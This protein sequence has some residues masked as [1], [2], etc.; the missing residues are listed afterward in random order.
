M[1]SS[2][3]FKWEKKMN[4]RV[5]TALQAMKAPLNHEKVTCSSSSSSFGFLVYSPVSCFSLLH[6]T[7]LMVCEH[8]FLFFFSIGNGKSEV[9]FFSLSIGK[10]GFNSATAFLVSD[11][12]FS[13]R[14][15]LRNW[16]IFFLNGSCRLQN[17]QKKKKVCNF[18]SKV[19]IGF[20]HSSQ[21]KNSFCLCFCFFFFF[22]P[23]LALS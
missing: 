14:I 13:M 19:C 2:F 6:S 10:I 5:R 16:I 21:E 9:F 3:V 12:W 4:T 20:F 7:I 17:L 23:F 15:L 11:A 22:T 1:H 8:G 18:R